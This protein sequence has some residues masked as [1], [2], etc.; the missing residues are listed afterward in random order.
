MNILNKTTE[1]IIF[2]NIHR[3]KMQGNMCKVMSTFDIV[4]EPTSLT[5]VNDEDFAL[6][7]KDYLESEY[8]KPQKLEVFKDLVSK[9]PKKVKKG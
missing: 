7:D 9:K 1:K 4:L 3:C 2:K 6:L 5:K 8:I